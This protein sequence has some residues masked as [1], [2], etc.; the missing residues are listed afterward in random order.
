MVIPGLSGGVI[1]VVL[2]IYDKMIYALNNLFINF[3][4]NF[5]FL[6]VMT[7]GVA[8]G[9]IWFSNII[10]VLYERYEVVTKLSFIGLILGGVPYLY[11]ESKGDNKNYILMLSTFLF[12]FILWYLSN[13]LLNVNLSNSN[14][15][16]SLFITGIVYS[17]GKIIPGISSSFLLIMIGKYEFVLRVIA[18]PITYA[19][20]NL[21][22]VIP[23][24]V[25]LILGIII[26]LKIVSFMLNKYYSKVYSII[27]GFVLGSLPA[28]IPSIEINSQLFLGT[29]LL[30]ALFILSYKMTKE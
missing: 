13:N 6:L 17:I 10:Y 5:V 4:K 1:A 3:K 8:V 19:I 27:V 30:I 14:S 11:K 9:A 26:L 24:L 29:F 18:H 7:L 25:G 21:P 23:F 22:L 16:F 28:V 2:G 20:K 15:I 12:S